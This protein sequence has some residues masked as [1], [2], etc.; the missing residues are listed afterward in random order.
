MPCSRPQA[1]APSP[2]WPRGQ[3]GKWHAT[4]LPCS[5]SAASLSPR[6]L[7][8]SSRARGQGPTGRLC[9][10][11]RTPRSSRCFHLPVMH[12]AASAELLWA[13]HAD[14]LPSGVASAAH[15]SHP[16]ALATAAG[17]PAHPPAHSTRRR[18]ATPLWHTRCPAATARRRLAPYSSLA[19]ALVLIASYHSPGVWR[20]G[21]D[22]WSLHGG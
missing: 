6:F 13:L 22:H 17:A 10:F 9:L 2:V 12:L 15:T 8:S 20:D 18:L 21:R 5:S 14:P 1:R 11:S 4:L 3:L 19:H 16:F 7:R